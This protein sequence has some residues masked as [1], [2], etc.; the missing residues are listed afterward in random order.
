MITMVTQLRCNKRLQNARNW[1][2]HGNTEDLVLQT[3]AQGVSFQ[4]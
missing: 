1:A 3:N 4:K 2:D